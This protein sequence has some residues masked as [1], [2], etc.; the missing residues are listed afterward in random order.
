MNI[1][2]HGDIRQGAATFYQFFVAYVQ[3][4]FTEDQALELVKTILQTQIITIMT[5][6][7]EKS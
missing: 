7:E 6:D 2:P 3:A 1:E 5:N 4:G